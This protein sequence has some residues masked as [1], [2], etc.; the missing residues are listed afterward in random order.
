LKNLVADGRINIKM[1]LEE[2][3]CKSKDWIDLVQVRDNWWDVVSA[4]INHYIS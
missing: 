1:D 4:E 3:G 2:T